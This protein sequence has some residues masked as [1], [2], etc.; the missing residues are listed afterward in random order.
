MKR[1]SLRSLTV[2]P[3]QLRPRKNAKRRNSGAF[4]CDCVLAAKGRQM[5]YFSRHGKIVSNGFG[6]KSL[7]RGYR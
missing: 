5:R 2:L 4:F 7:K 1:K 6:N 3:T